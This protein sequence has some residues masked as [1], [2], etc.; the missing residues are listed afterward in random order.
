MNDPS[1]G[2][3]SN[4]HGDSQ[5]L[6]HPRTKL[7]LFLS[8][9]CL[10]IVRGVKQVPLVPAASFLTFVDFFGSCQ[11]SRCFGFPIVDLFS[12]VK[13]PVVF[14]HVRTTG[15]IRSRSLQVS[16]FSFYYVLS[17][18]QPAGSPDSRPLTSVFDRRYCHVSSS[19]FAG[20]SVDGYWGGIWRCW[21]SLKT[22][23]AQPRIQICTRRFASCVWR[24][25]W[26]R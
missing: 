16:L 10:Q 1:L 24:F 6:A 4:A 8:L 3:G 9:Q 7:L 13:L 2:F 22:R 14:G 12:L 26:K 15:P 5:R 21:R 18:G 19:T 11:E 17:W 23:Y 20:S 25:G